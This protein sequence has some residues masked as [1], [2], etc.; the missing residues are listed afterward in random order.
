MLT[1]CLLYTYFNYLLPNSD[2]FAY[3]SYSLLICTDEIIAVFESPLIN[4][5]TCIYPVTRSV[6]MWSDTNIFV[7]VQCAC[8]K[9]AWLVNKIKIMFQQTY[10]HSSTMI[11]NA[12]IPGNYL[13]LHVTLVIVNI[14]YLQQFI[15]YHCRLSFIATWGQ[16]L[17]GNKGM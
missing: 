6:G 5:M 3:T 1:P 2:L 11:G 13:L 12:V 8:Y 14:I 9:I 17:S 7:F 4:N 16:T 15:D 10:P